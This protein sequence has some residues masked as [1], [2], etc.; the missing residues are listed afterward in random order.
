MELVVEVFVV[1]VA[2]RLVL[3]EIPSGGD[4]PSLVLV[5]V[6]L[7]L[8]FVLEDCGRELEDADPDEHLVS[9][10]VTD[11]VDVVLLMMV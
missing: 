10:L 11:T 1:V 8:S 7:L 4:R 2:G 3:L 9:V 5:V 6:I